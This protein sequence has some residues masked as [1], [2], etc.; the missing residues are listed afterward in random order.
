MRER[1]RESGR[2]VRSKVVLS[3]RRN[4]NRSSWL[5]TKSESDTET[6]RVRVSRTEII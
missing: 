5:L 3:G 4:Q 1:E 6:A 2:E